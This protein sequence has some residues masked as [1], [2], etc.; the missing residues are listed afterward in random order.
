MNTGKEIRLKR[1]WK[2]RRTVI[3]P[4]DHG[5]YS[6][7]VPGLE[8]PRTLTERIARTNADAVLVTPGVLRNITPAL[9]S[10]GIIL[11]IDGGFT[12]YATTAT[13]YLPIL[14]PDEAVALGADAAIVF[15]FVGTPDESVSLQRLGRTAAAAGICGLPV[16]SEVL[17]PGFLHNHFGSDV[18]PKPAAG[19]NLGE[20]TKNVTRIA[21]ELGA[22]IIKTRYT[23]DV[24]QFRSVVQTCGAPVIVAGGP[25]T[26]G[27][28]AA[29]LNLTHEC[30]R[31]GAAGI[32]FGRTVW[33]HPRMEKLI[34]AICLIVH[35]DEGVESAIKLLR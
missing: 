20:E 18:F 10:L 8:D 32:V 24:E 11:R 25:G 4:F 19:A 31:A 2:H 14:E 7:V 30:V 27:T 34:N 3:I 28:D 23:G 29:L 1:I 17:A 22:D 13:D 12:S 9:G 26:K 15:T 21:A 33:Q 16:V 6:G 5:S 35:E